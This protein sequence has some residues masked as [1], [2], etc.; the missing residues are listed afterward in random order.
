MVLDREILPRLA[1]WRGELKMGP[2][3]RYAQPLPLP[4]PVALSS[5]FAVGCG[6]TVL[7]SAA[8]EA[9]RAAC[10][11]DPY[12][13]TCYFYCTSRDPS[14]QD[15]AVLLRLLLLQLCY[16]PTVSE[17]LQGLYDVCNE[18]YPPKK[19]TIKELS[20]T[21]QAMLENSGY[22]D[23]SEPPSW[24][25]GES[26]KRGVYVLIDG[27]DEIPWNERG[28]SSAFSLHWLV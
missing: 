6:K 4:V 13:K 26:D 17:P 25:T 27:L 9:T 15:V 16:P 5:S 28:I 20:R 22:T 3:K 8:V 19:A 24:T 12:K 18:V 1:P 11:G 21:L 10:R 23:L 2:W 7:F 14:G